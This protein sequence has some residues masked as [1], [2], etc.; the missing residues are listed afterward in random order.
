MFFDDTINGN[1]GNCNY[2]GE[3]IKNNIFGDFLSRLVG[4]F[5]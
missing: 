4:L 1:L 5:S 3:R 2:L